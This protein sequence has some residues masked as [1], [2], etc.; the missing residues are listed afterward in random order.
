MTEAKIYVPTTDAK[1]P[2]RT[3]NQIHQPRKFTEGRRRVSIYVCWSFP[4]EA[5]RDIRARQPVLD[6][7]GGTARRVAILGNPGMVGSDDVSTGDCWRAGAVLS[8]VD[9]V[10]A[11]RRRGHGTL[12]PV[13]QR[14]D[15]AGYRLPLDERVLADTD[16]LFVFGLDH[17]LTEQEASPEKSR[18]FATG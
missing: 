7:D 10:P 8:R 3:Y 15:Q 1:T 9:A 14:V 6:D 17:L 2:A 13:F 16:T 4:G 5:N 18:P 12:V 11:A